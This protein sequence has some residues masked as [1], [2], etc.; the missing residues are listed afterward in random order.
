[1]VGDAFGFLDPIYSSGVFLALKSGE[2]AA[3]AITAALAA[4]DLSAPRLG[5]YGEEYLKGMEAVR[6]LVYAFYTREFSF[7]RFLRAHPECKQGWLTS[8]AATSFR[9][10]LRR[11]SNPCPECVVYQRISAY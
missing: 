2:W 4:G 5:G 6:K 1:M 3:D 8:S 7:A 10:G 9:D 11:S